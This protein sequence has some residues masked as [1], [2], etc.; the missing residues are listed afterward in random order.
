MSKETPIGSGLSIVGMALSFFP[1]T[2]VIGAAVMVVGAGV[3]YIEASM[4]ETPE[5]E[6]YF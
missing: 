1:P 4:I 6:A 2:S 3:S 5:E